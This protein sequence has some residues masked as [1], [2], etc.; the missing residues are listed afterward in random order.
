M[1]HERVEETSAL[2]LAGA[3]V[4][5]HRGDRGIPVP[6]SHVVSF[7]TSGHDLDTTAVL[8]VL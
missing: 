1:P 4:Q 7:R 3:E 6:A 2:D 8:P 5:K